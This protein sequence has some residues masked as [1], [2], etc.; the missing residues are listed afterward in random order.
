M[1]NTNLMIA[2][3]AALLLIVLLAVIFIIIKKKKKQNKL[4]EPA[5]L[6]LKLSQTKNGILGKL[7]EVVKLRG[8]VDEEL[9]EDLEEML[10]KSDIG[11]ETSIEIIDQLRQ[12]VRQE[13]ITQ[14]G[15]IQGT[16]K[17]IIRKLLL[18]DYANTNEHF[19]L[20]QASPFIFLF[21]GVNGVGKTTTIG[22]LAKRYTSAGKKVRLIAGDTFRAAAI[23]QLTIW[24][25]RSGAEI[26]KHQHGADPASVI[27]EGVMKAVK[28]KEDIVL[29][30]TAGRQHTKI[31][32]MN[33]LS[34]IIRT[35]QKIVPAAPHET[36][37]V[38]DATTGQN[39]IEQSKLFNQ[40]AKLTGLVLTKLDGTAKGGIVI[41]IKHQL[42]I[43][44]K[45]IGV[46]EQETDLRD[47]EIDQFIEAIFE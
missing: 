7:A 29:I 19:Q 46:G 15:E 47:F 27:Y 25:E 35:I 3:A 22:K 28:E 11:V 31:N 18:A 2:A 14:V 45:L 38:V 33:E 6:K 9:M 1:Y 34:K 37:M 12:E 13:Q 16:L 23:E 10:I 32:L 30:D 24:A 5:D 17:K 8:K 41:G 42:N 40:A 21:A 39:A 36:M 44:V 4:S 43:P 26:T 20:E